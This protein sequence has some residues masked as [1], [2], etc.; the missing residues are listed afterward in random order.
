M[1]NDDFEELISFFTE[2]VKEKE[3][4]EKE[5]EKDEER[6]Q[7][8]INRI[9]RISCSRVNKKSSPMMMGRILGRTSNKKEVFIADTG[10]SIIILPVNI[11]KRNGVVWTPVDS[12]EPSYVG[13][14]GVEVDIQGQANV[15]T[16][17]DNI[18]GGYNLQVQIARQ[19]AEEICIDLDTLIDLSIIPPDIPLPK[20][21]RDE[22]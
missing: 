3:K 4:K 5:E 7:K 18:K 19:K 15:R 20:R 1:F 11:A 2:K 10:T 21:P 12:D 8:Y 22:I 17:F 6:L 16:V 13:V 14:T 9:R